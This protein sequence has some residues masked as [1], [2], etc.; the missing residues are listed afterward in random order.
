MVNYF[1]NAQRL[2][3]CKCRDFMLALYRLVFKEAL[4]IRKLRFL[5][6]ESSGITDR[7]FAIQKIYVVFLQKVINRFKYARD[8]SKHIFCHLFLSITNSILGCMVRNDFN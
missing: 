8:M 6:G 4:L 5:N 2:C 7:T 1:T 3:I